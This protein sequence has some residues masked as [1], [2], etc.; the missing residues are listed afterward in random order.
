MVDD[1][2]RNWEALREEVLERDGYECR[3]C[4]ITD[5]EHRDTYGRGLDVHHIVSREDEATDRKRNLATLCQSCHRTLENLH[6]Q[7][8]TGV[9]QSRYGDDLAGVNY[10]FN[11]YRDRV[12]KFESE[13]DAFVDGH[14]IF[15]K[16]FAIVDE[17]PDG[18]MPAIHVY[19]WGDV[20][21]LPNVGEISSEWEF[22]AAWGY[23]KGVFH[24]VSN[25]DSRAKLPF[26]EIGDGE[27]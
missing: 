17:N 20:V 23:K 18:D 9:I 14:P 13:L 4:E 11:M 6:E 7:A 5:D 15:A 1:T 8:A 24:V 3:F 12:R 25:L 21:S 2:D 19:E 27:D 16:R 22:A 10:V 26:E